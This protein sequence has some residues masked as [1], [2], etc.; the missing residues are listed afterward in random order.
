MEQH[1]RNWKT[2]KRKLNKSGRVKISANPIFPQ[3]FKV[4]SVIIVK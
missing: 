1:K 2:G 4:K 3:D